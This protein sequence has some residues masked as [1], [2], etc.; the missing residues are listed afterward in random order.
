MENNSAAGPTPDE[1]SLVL[2]EALDARDRFTAALVLPS[3]FF[4]SLGVVIA[5]Q[6]ATSAVGIAAQDL[7]GWLLVIAGWAAL[8]V[9]AGVQL[10]RF[11]RANGV[12][13]RGLA[14]RVVLGATEAAG[15][16]YA[17]A[18]AAG[19]WAAFEG[20][21]WLVAASSLAGGVAY[22]WSGRRWWRAYRSDPARHGRDVSQ[23][24]LACLAL[25][26]LVGAVVLLTAG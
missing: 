23:L 13:V 24:V 9:V 15:V 26:G 18:L 1:A 10:T 7:A 21:G 11:R 19:I 17:A 4:A 5:A 20:A 2:A 3:Y 12:R 22:A 6:I 14:D 8:A 16:A 25:A